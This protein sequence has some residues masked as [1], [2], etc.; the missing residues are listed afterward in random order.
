MGKL[1]SAADY[2]FAFFGSPLWT[3]RNI[4]TYPQNFVKTD[5]LREFIRINIVV[6]PGIDKGSSTGLLKVEIFT[7][8]GQSIDR[9]VDIADAL[10][11]TLENKTFGQIQ[12]TN[13]SMY[14]VDPDSTKDYEDPTLFKSIY[15]INFNY[16][17]VL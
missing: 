1:L 5:G 10:N 17:G 2:V 12:Y 9:A 15:T 8:A 7:P 6:G 4:A 13:G 3:S 16:F 14:H 11:D